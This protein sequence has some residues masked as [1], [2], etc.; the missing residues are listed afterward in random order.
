MISAVVM[1]SHNIWIHKVSIQFYIFLPKNTP[2]TKQTC[3]LRFDSCSCGL[4]LRI[5]IISVTYVC[6]ITWKMC[7]FK[8]QNCSYFTAKEW[9][10]IRCSFIHH[11]PVLTL[12]ISQNT[13]FLILSICFSCASTLSHS[14][15]S[16]FLP[17]TFWSSYC[18]AWPFE[19][20]I[21]S[22][23]RL[24]MKTKTEMDVESQVFTPHACISYKKRC[25][26]DD[27]FHYHH[28]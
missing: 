25:S 5:F 15:K 12:V 10:T 22:P 19:I 21:T 26:S 28:C 20:F 4:N 18:G 16:N 6:L 7:S 14:F 2:E 24:Q 9:N 13:D 11:R 3:F 23:S 17:Q 1:Q 27:V 8:M